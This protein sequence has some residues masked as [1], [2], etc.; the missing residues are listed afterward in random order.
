LWQLK[1]RRQKDATCQC[2]HPQ[3]RW[4]KLLPICLESLRRQTFQHFDITV[5]DNGSHDGSLNFLRERYP[6]V[7]IIP[8]DRNYGFAA[9]V[10]REIE[11]TKNEFISICCKVRIERVKF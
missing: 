6:E 5:V 10:N 3:S 7:R 4:E 2:D 1:E 9:A 11:A 8:L